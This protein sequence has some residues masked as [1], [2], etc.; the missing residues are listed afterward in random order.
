MVVEVVVRP[1]SSMQGE[2]GLL[3]MRPN[4]SVG[5]RRLYRRLVATELDALGVVFDRDVAVVY[6]VAVT[7]S[8]VPP[9]P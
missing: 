1:R 5:D 3:V 6:G 2:R 8:A 7:P 9:T 4:S